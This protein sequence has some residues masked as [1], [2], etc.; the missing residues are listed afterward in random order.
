MDRYLEALGEV[1]A[2][3]GPRGV[4]QLRAEHVRRAER[5]RSVNRGRDRQPVGAAGGAQQ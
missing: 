5:C 2:R 1:R 3:V 4:F